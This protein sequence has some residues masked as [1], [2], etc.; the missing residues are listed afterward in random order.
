MS[1]DG[2]GRLN[3]TA[4]DR[5]GNIVAGASVE[6]RIEGTGITS[7]PY[8]SL[9]LATL[10]SNRGGTVS[11]GNPFVTDAN[12]YGFCYAVTGQYAV[13][14]QAQGVE[15]IYRDVQLGDASGGGGGGDVTLAG[16]NTF[17]GTNFF[18][19]DTTFGNP[20]VSR[21]T[22]AGRLG[23]GTLTPS[24]KFMIRDVNTTNLWPAAYVA[25][26]A[27]ANTNELAVIN[28]GLN[29]A[30]T[31]TGLYFSPGQTTVAGSVNVAR[32]GAVRVAG[33]DTDIVFGSR[34]NIAQFAERMR[35]RGNG[36]VG[37]GTASPTA[38]LHVNGTIRSATYT[39]ASL[40]SAS[41]AGAGARAA[42]TDATSL[43]FASTVAGGGSSFVPV[44]SNGSVWR[45]G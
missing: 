12:G 22:S 34:N 27:F 28:D 35:I 42:V 36:T 15:T 3:L 23:L 9:A 4:T 20:A 10:T 2:R 29:T 31:Y 33:F 8:T 1:I 7:T 40:P 39:V 21:F 24:S 18:Q 32:I 43:V 25:N 19:N 41:V 14:I 26:A 44:I 45:I 38:T 37:I 11:Q 30:N 17:S 5:Y 16:N 13:R 6:V